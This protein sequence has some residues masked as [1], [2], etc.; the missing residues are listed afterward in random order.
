MRE[1]VKSRSGKRIVVVNAR[2]AATLHPAGI[3]WHTAPISVVLFSAPLNA[4]STMWIL[5]APRL[6]FSFQ[7]LVKD[8]A[9]HVL[10]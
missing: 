1:F 4:F 7:L 5:G 3:R 9:D 6:T 10:P 2:L 8:S